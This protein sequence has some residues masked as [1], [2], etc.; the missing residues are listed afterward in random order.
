MKSTYKK[1]LLFAFI[2][3]PLL[4][5]A[6]INISNETELK[7][8]SEDLEGSYILTNDITLTGIW[9]PI[10]STSPFKGILDGNGH[11][12]RNL[13]VNETGQ[14]HAGLFA[15]TEDAEIRDLRIE[16]A[17]VTS[18][19]NDNNIYTGILIGHAIGTTIN[20]ISVSGGSVKSNGTVGSIAGQAEYSEETRY[21]T[22]VYDSYSTAEVLSENG[23]AGG[24]IGVTIGVL[25]ENAYFSGKAEGV[26]VVGGIVGST[27]YL[28]MISSCLVTSPSLKGVTSGRIVGR[29]LTGSTVFLHNNYAR[30]DLLIGYS[31]L[32]AIPDSKSYIKGLQGENIPYDSPGYASSLPPYTNEDITVALDAFNRYFYSTGRKLYAEK[33]SGLDRGK[34][35]AIW[36]QAIYWDMA[37][38]AYLRTGSEA[39]KKR[40]DDL[41]EGNGKEYDNYNWDNGVKWFIYDDI[42]WWVV[43]LARAYE[44][45]GDDKYLNLSKTGFERVW[46]GSKVLGDNGS[47]DPVNGGMFWAWNNSNP[48]GSPDP[49][50]G[51][52]SCINY[53]TVVA[54]MTL[55]NATKDSTYFD[56]GLEIYT[57]SRNNLFDAEIGC[58]AD[59]RHGMGNPAWVMHV[60]NQATCIGAAVMLYKA[61]GERQYLDD[62]ILAA[63]YTKNQMGK[64]GFLHFETGIEQG[65]YHAIFA[66]YIAR[67]IEDGEQYQYVPWLRYNI[68]YGWKNRIASSNVVYKDYINPAP[69][70]ANM[71]SYDAS[72]IPALM[73]VIPPASD[74]DKV[75]NCKSRLF[76]EKNL[77]WDFDTTWEWS[78]KDS[79]PKLIS[80]GTSSVEKQNNNNRME[81][82]CR[83]GVLHIS[84]DV[85][86]TIEVYD[87]VGHI[88]AKRN[89]D[90][91]GSI[92]L[93]QGLYIVR[94]S[95]GG[96]SMV[97]KVMVR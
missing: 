87:N 76:Y 32:V 72:G 80:S 63:N 97:Q 64:N 68:D 17:Q 11:V 12:I 4:V 51:K 89:I 7:A 3:L 44:I 82:Y 66:Q 19:L 86:T 55:F 35:A 43:S 9:E 18:T 33:N 62:A 88:C 67:L 75:V 21:L 92:V 57:W 78:E 36:V 38:N 70:L 1:I 93:P 37:M 46:S 34:V 29:N 94:A 14:K 58:V 84:V 59:S 74:N 30:A 6:Q 90:K 28:N 96:N 95:D 79:A 20:N 26:S 10:G 47:Y 56:K 40:M 22:A 77:N 25:I 27:E 71:D 2:L 15:V 42:M 8:I 81:A 54:A 91:K 39:D 49:G 53:P 48:V 45:T 31:K 50:M 69:A 61:T 5:Q 65:I 13:K 85:P 23:I 52:M 41:F 73:Q 16:N 60:Y 83:D 24:L